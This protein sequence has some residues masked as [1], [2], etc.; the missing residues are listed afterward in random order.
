M[1][2][3]AGTFWRAERRPADEP[4][5]A[6]MCHALTHRGPDDV[7]IW[8]NGPASIGMRRLSI[9][10]LAGGHQP[11]FNETG[12]IGIVLNGEI[13]NY[14]ELRDQLIARGHQFRTTSDTEVIV[15][16]YEDMGVRCVEALRGMFAFAIWDSDAQ[17]LLLARDRFG[18]KPL[19][20]AETP[21][22]IAFASE[23]K[24]LIAA[25]LT[26]RTIDDEALDLY[27]QLGYM[28]A[29]WSPLKGVRK[30]PPAHTLVCRPG[31]APEMHRYWELPV[32]T[33]AMPSDP[34]TLVRDALDDS[35][36]AHLCAD[37]PIAAFLSGGIDSSAIVAS[38]ALQGYPVHA[39]TARY[40]GSGA[41][42]T[43]E[44]PLAKAL[45]EKYGLTL[46]VVDIEPNVRDLLDP[47]AFA[48]DEP[49]ADESSLPTWL[50]SRAVS[51]NFKVALSGTGGDELFG[52]YR[53]HRAIAYGGMYSRVPAW[54]RR[55]V[56]RTVDALPERDGSGLG[57][58]RAKRFL[59][60]TAEGP[61]AQY[62]S[63]VTR[64]T[65]EE[66]HELRGRERDA[67]RHAT[68]FG[69]L[70]PGGSSTALRSALAIDYGGYLPDDLLALSDRIS[71]AHSLEVRVPFVDHV[72]IER[73]LPLPD[74]LR[75]R[76][77]QLKWALRMATAPRLTPAHLSAPKRGFVGPTASWLRHELRDILED[78]LSAARLERL[79]L[80]Q[81]A[82]V[83]RWIQEHASGR[84][85]REGILWALLSFMVWHR[86]MLESPVPRTAPAPVAR[87][88][89]GGNTS[90]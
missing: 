57:L 70:A 67:A 74:S 55:G 20:I 39:F 84:R 64:L 15:H 81:A 18:I 30:L 53:R 36:R 71:S 89:H 35:V 28:P 54:L 72:L 80:F 77:G 41:A 59:R 45:A 87:A 48:L 29:P 31:R 51:E 88:V 12:T 1:C 7:G 9:I 10:D 33:V 4:S 66:F 11:I 13:F 6:T 85:N 21:E 5:V 69:R 26:D 76:Q 65:G 25:G 63:F 19:Y 73:L 52:G 47:I 14:R 17:T 40:L 46:S 38:M 61:I 82:P 68:L 83:A 60:T 62:A 3:I 24:A 58:T 50:I 8:S 44:W 32:G 42:G 90:H 16:L 23:L 34:A 75:H 2:G 37:V 56:S 79:G 43:E 78:E 86:V 49:L 22:R 27:L